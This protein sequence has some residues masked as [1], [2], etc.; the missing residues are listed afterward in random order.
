MVSREP[1]YPHVP[2]VG[3]V[4]GAIRRNRQR[5]GRLQLGITSVT[6]ITWGY[7]CGENEK[8]EQKEMEV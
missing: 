7:I 6:S 4:E 8:K 3:D 1:A 2:E 5:R